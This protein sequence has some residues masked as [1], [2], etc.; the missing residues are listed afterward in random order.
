MKNQ[1]RAL[2]RFHRKRVYKRRS[3]IWKSYELFGLS[4]SEKILQ[5]RSKTPVACSCW[6]CGNP[7][8]YFGDKSNQEL[9]AIEKFKSDWKDLVA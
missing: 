6:K 4:Y 5:M 9:K 3:E 7:R 2:R 8:K 1:R